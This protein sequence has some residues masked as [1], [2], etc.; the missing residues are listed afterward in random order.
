MCVGFWSLTHRDY[1]L[2][3]CANRDEFLARPT[4]P[5]HFH[6][7]ETFSKSVTVTLTDHDGGLVVQHEGTG[8]VLSGRDVQAGGTWLGISQRTGRVAFLTNITEPGAAYT[9]SRGTLVA[10]FL[11]DPRE[12]LASEVS[13]LMGQKTAYAGFNLLLLEPLPFT[14][15]LAYGARLVTNGGGGGKIQGRELNEGECISGGISNG[16]DGQGGDSWPKVVQGREMLENVL[17]EL[18]PS[19]ENDHSPIS[20]PRTRAELKN[21]ILVPPFN[22]SNNNNNNPNAPPAPAT[23]T[24]Y[25]TRLAQVI[26]VRRDGRVTYVE[27]DVWMLDDQGA[28]V[29]A[30]PSNM[31]VFTFRLES[32]AHESV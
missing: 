6:S 27:H 32:T 10:S 1:A 31:R 8:S 19:P 26:L 24:I 30:S 18:S 16:V 4:L 12:D 15:R 20:P 23:T 2:I 7:F 11:T 5:A 9:S 17:D 28:P 14:D 22:T 21:T 29:R 3:L 25:G 13:A